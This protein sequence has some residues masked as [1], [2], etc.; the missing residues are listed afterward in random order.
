MRYLLAF[1]P[2]VLHSTHACLRASATSPEE[3][4]RLCAAWTK[5]VILTV[6]IWTLPYVQDGLW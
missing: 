6:T 1:I 3:V 5:A 4:D 2:P